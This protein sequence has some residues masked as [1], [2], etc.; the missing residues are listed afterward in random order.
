MKMK[1]WVKS[2]D[3]WIWMIGG[4]LGISLI[5]VVGLLTLIAVRGFSHFWPSPLIETTW[6]T[7]STV[8]F[9]AGVPLSRTSMVSPSLPCA[10]LYSSASNFSKLGQFMPRMCR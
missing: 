3:P 10:T 4:A 7:S 6:T 8:S 5:M 9:S 2:G 1:T